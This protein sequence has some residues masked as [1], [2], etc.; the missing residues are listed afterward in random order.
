MSISWRRRVLSHL[1]LRPL[2][3]LNII[4]VEIIPSID[5][6]I[7]TEDIDIVLESHTGMKWSLIMIDENIQDKEHFTDLDCL[8]HTNTNSLGI[9]LEVWISEFLPFGVS[10]FIIVY[11][12]ISN[13]FLSAKD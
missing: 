7:P 2:V 1:Y 12:N 5:T 13:L 11:F 8:S 6:I 9:F 4:L 10:I 3:L